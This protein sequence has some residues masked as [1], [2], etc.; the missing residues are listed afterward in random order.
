MTCDRAANRSLL[1][2]CEVN[3][4]TVRAIEPCVSMSLVLDMH[5]EATVP[6]WCI[7]PYSVSASI[8]VESATIVDFMNNIVRGNMICCAGWATQKQDA[9]TGTVPNP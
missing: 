1:P 6:S 2:S 8:H 7:L 3:P 9:V 5:T 4:T